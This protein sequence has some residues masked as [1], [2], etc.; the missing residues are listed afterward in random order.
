M[1]PL[2]LA[3]NLGQLSHILNLFRFFSKLARASRRETCS[4]MISPLKEAFRRSKEQREKR[5]APPT[6]HPKGH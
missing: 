2:R 6:A 5:Q 1:D 4:G 3:P